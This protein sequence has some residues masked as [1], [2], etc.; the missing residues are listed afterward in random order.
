MPCPLAH[1]G[2]SPRC[3]RP[4]LCQSNNTAKY[5]EVI[6]RI[7]GRAGPEYTLDRAFVSS[8]DSR[9]AQKQERLE[10]ELHHNKTNLIKESIRMGEAGHWLAGR[11]GKQQRR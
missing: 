11:A 6:G 9:A 7:A 3:C 1:G 2:S 10:S 8:V 4:A 5:Q